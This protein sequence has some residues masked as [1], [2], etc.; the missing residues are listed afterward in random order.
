LGICFS[1][2]LSYPEAI[3]FARSAVVEQKMKYLESGTIFRDPVLMAVWAEGL[4]AH[5]TDDSSDWDA[6]VAMSFKTQF[7]VS[8]SRP[9]S[10]S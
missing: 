3:K 5:H 6:A 4:V 1:R 10:P 9:S 2:S 8:Y 7:K